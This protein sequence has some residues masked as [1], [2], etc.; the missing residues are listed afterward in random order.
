MKNR[1]QVR[2]SLNKLLDQIDRRSIEYLR[3]RRVWEFTN[4][5]LSEISLLIDL[6]NPWNRP[7]LGDT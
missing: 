4:K 2:L 5:T 6:D 3:E 1:H 7:I